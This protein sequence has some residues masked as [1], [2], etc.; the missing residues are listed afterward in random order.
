MRKNHENRSEARYEALKAQSQQPQNEFYS[1][2]VDIVL[3]DVPT[4]AI[5]ALADNSRMIKRERRPKIKEIRSRILE[6]SQ[7]SV[8]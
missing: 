3:V 1:T 4:F 7:D 5:R 2:V 6:L 8:K